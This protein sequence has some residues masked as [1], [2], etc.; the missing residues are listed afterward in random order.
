MAG[1]GSKGNEARLVSTAGL[2]LICAVIALLLLFLLPND[3]AR[4]NSARQA[5]LDVTTPVIRV[6]AWPFQK[7]GDL[8]RGTSDI[9]DLR[10]RVA[11]LEAENRALKHQLD[12]FER[13]SLLVGQYQRLLSLPQEPELRMTSGRVVADISSPFVHSILANTGRAA[14]V[15]EGQAVIGDE[16]LVGRVVSVGPN[17]SRILLLT[18]FS[19]KIPVV[20]LASNVR[21]IL[22]GR[23][24]ARPTLEF[25]PRGAAL[26]DGDLL[27]T[28]GDGGSMPVGLPVGTARFDSDEALYIELQENLKQLDYVRV[29]LASTITAPPEQREGFLPNNEGQR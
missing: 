24:S 5:V 18:D 10:N 14:G 27:V 23:N 12:E 22:V 7:I 13:L 28:S 8:R 3:D 21:G 19:S 1:I 11:A 16:G 25:L 20:A 26:K 4:L 15:L 6:L 9:L 17:S 2:T 29:V